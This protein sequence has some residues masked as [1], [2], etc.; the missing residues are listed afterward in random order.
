M[1]CYEGLEGRTFLVTGASSGIG[2]GTALLLA[3]L[4]ARVVA[5]GRDAARLGQVMAELQ[6]DGHCA[7]EFH[8]ENGQEIPGEMKRLAAA[9][10][11]FAGLVH[12]AGLQP[13]V[14]LKVMGPAQMEKAFAVNVFAA[15][16][17]LRG[18]RQ[19]GVADP[20]RLA[21]AVL[22]SSVMGQVGQPLQTLY[23][24]T[25]GSIEAMVRASALELAPD[26]IRVNAVAPGAV[27]TE[28]TAKLQASLTEGQFAAIEAMHPLGLGGLSDVVKP[29]AF[30]LSTD[31][32][33]ITGTTLVVDGGYLAS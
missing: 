4:G 17:L 14:P 6:G 20:A 24:A 21:S 11:P 9:M 18:L 10:G 32:N 33:W 23:C 15:L 16:G 25:K 26:R 7:W 13:L 5:Q 22:L 29:I 30:L 28:M 8:L 3:A 2:R 31:S 27:R 12:C 1:S 19:K